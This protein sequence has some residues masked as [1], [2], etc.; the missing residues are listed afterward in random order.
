MAISSATSRAAPARIRRR[1]KPQIIASESKASVRA[2]VLARLCSRFQAARGYH[3]INRHQPAKGRVRRLG[4][5]DGHR[6]CI[7]ASGQRSPAKRKS[8]LMVAIRRNKRDPFLMRLNLCVGACYLQTGADSSPGTVIRYGSEPRHREP[9]NCLKIQK[10]A[11]FARHSLRAQSA[12]QADERWSRTQHAASARKILYDL[13]RFEPH[14]E[15][16]QA[17]GDSRSRALL[18]RHPGMR[19]RRRPRDEALD[20]AQ[21]GRR[22][23]QRDVVDET[24]GGGHPALQFEAQHPAEA[25]EQLA[26]A[27]M[28][29]AALESRALMPDLG[30]GF[31][32][33]RR[34]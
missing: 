23:G 34:S 4:F 32:K 8:R 1:L 25:V 19:G 5:P 28:V 20:S 29:G 6:Q 31:E 24:V 15:P 33:A 9:R 22:D 18:G 2:F 30:M 26:G 7:L 3:G 16:D 27:Q 10:T 21:A 13:G 14:R 17:L 11:A 12:P